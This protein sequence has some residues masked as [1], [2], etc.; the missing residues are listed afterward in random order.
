MN[1]PARKI[2]GLVLLVL[3]FA[4]SPVI[5]EEQSA[6][7]R[8]FFWKINSPTSTVYLFAT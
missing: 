4:Y 3:L 6:G 1:C 7:D 5:A 2:L 8:G